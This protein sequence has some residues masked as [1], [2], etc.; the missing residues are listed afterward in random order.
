MNYVFSFLFFLLLGCDLQSG[1][2][3]SKKIDFEEVSHFSYQ[4][5]A[6]NYLILDTQAKIDSVY[7]IIHSKTEGNRLA[8]IPTI[9]PDE[10]YIVFKPVLKNSNDIEIRNIILENNILYINVHE[11]NNPQVPRTNRGVPNVLVK[12]L[13]EI[14]P[15]KIN[16]NYINNSN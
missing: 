6:R 14:N 10:T 8:P 9:L 4:L 11:F 3:S 12:L 7:K 13:K 15:N 1:T 5:T 16:I 2:I